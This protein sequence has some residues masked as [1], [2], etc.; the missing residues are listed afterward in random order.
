MGNQYNLNMHQTKCNSNPEFKEKMERENMERIEKLK[1]D[2]EKLTCRGCMRF[3]KHE[4]LYDLHIRQCKK[5]ADYIVNQ[6]L[7]AEN[8]YANIDFDTIPDVDLQILLK[9]TLQ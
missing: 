9:N 1:N 4:K 7:K 2:H 8:E 5:Y 6:A 3:L